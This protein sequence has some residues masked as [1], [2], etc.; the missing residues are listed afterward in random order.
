MHIERFKSDLLKSDSR[1]KGDYLL[2]ASRVVHLGMPVK[3]AEAL[4]SWC[5]ITCVN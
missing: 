5:T 1:Y 3:L 4:L 2:D